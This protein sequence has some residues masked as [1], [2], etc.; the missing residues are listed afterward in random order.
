VSFRRRAEN[1]KLSADSNLPLDEQTVF[2][3][4][5]FSRRR[6]TIAP[7]EVVEFYPSY[8]YRPEDG[9]GWRIVVQGC[10]YKPNLPWFRRRP[11]MAVIRRAMKVDRGGDTYFRQRMQRFL[12]DSQ[13]GRQLTIRIDGELF[14]AGESDP[15]GLFRQEIDIGRELPARIAERDDGE[16]LWVGF[17]AALAEG[18]DRQFAGRVQLIEPE[19]LSIV[20]DVDDTIKHSNVPNRRDL[21]HNTF[22]R[23]FAPI[24]GMVELYQECARKGAAFH[25]VSGSPWQLYNPLAEFLHA[26]QFPA[27]SFHLKPFRIRDTARKIRGPTPQLSHKRRA[28]EPILKAFPRRRFLLIGD[29]GEQDPLVYG[30]FLRERPD[31]IAGVFI[32]AIN[33]VTADDPR[34]QAAFQGCPAERWRLY[35]EP[36]EIQGDVVQLLEAASV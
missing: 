23:E 24:V 11:V 10:V 19:G 21:F 7:Q 28:I 31:Q 3:F 5:V 36:S 8:G 32:R 12:L 30:G 34:L 20:S 2:V 25:F 13:T 15:A 22:A 6:T 1:G 16:R 35:R 14:A 18:D 33:G 26:H 9:A 27:G 4:R 17:S 29:S